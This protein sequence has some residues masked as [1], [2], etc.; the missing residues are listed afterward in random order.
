MT[1]ELTRVAS[2]ADNSAELKEFNGRALSRVSELERQLA[3]FVNTPPAFGAR[4]TGS[5]WMDHLLL[6]EKTPEFRRSVTLKPQLTD[7]RKELTSGKNIWRDRLAKWQLTGVTPY[8]PPPNRARR[9]CSARIRRACSARTPRR[10]AWP[11]STR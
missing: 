6:L 4:N 10:S 5:A 9:S 3:N 8:A 7:I 11:R 2:F 1:A